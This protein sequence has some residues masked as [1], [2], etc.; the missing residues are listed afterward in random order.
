MGGVTQDLS[1][2]WLISLDMMSCWVIHAVAWVGVLCLFMAEHR[3]LLWMGRIWLAR[4]FVSGSAGCLPFG[5]CDGGC[6][7]L[8]PVKAHRVAAPL[9]PV[10]LAGPGPA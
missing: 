9:S 3:S 1:C 7:R 4:S 5:C 6:A 10:I 2:V 8:G